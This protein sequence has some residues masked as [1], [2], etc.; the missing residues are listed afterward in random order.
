MFLTPCIAIELYNINQQN[1]YRTHSCTYKTAY[2]DAR[3][4]YCTIP[5]YITVFL[6]MNPMVRNKKKASKN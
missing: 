3:K 1:L 6:K 2:T 4:M 5:V